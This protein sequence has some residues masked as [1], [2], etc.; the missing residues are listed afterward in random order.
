MTAQG[1]TPRR[2]FARDILIAVLAVICS[3]GIQ[4]LI[5]FK[6]YVEEPQGIF[7]ET[8]FQSMAVLGGTMTGTSIITTT[9]IIGW[10]DTSRLSGITAIP[11]FGD[12][13][14][15]LLKANTWILG[16]MTILSI[17]LMAL[18]VSSHTDFWVIPVYVPVMATAINYLR[19][20]IYMLYMAAEL[21]TR[22]RGN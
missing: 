10:W 13:M 18:R 17:C 3:M 14:L 1:W 21:V 7:R 5:D 12:T 22:T 6:I 8:V 2:H 19:R 20:T 15:L 4:W 9:M 11:E 16:T